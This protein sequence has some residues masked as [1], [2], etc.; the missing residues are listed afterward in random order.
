MRINSYFFKAMPSI[1]AKPIE[2]EPDV[3]LV[4]ATQG[5]IMLELPLPFKWPTVNY[6]TTI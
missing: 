1:R 6:A 5:G 2:L 3:S 4:A